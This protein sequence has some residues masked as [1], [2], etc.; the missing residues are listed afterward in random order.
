MSDDT[1][2]SVKIRTPADL[3]GVLPVQVGFAPT[4]SLVLMLLQGERKLDYATL[5]VD[6]PDRR[7][8]A[9]VC[10]ELAR[11]LA[12]LAVDAALVVVY[13]EEPAPARGLV[14]APFVRTLR[15]ALGRVGIEVADM[16]LVR[17][18]RWWCYGCTDSGGCPPEGTPLPTQPTSPALAL[19]AEQVTRGVVQ[20]PSREALAA[21][22]EG[23][24]VPA[25]LQAI[26][27]RVG[28]QVDRL[29]LD[30]ESRTLEGRLRD[31]VDE[32]DAHWE[33]GDPTVSDEQ[34]I[35]LALGLRQIRARDRVLTMVTRPR[36]IDRLVSV[37]CEIVR[38]V[39]DPLAAPPCAVL[40]WYAYAAGN[41]AL[42]AL[43][44]E[45]ALRAEPEYSLA[46]LVLQSLADFVPPTVIQDISVAV[47]Q[48]LDSGGDL[49][50]M[51]SLVEDECLYH[52][53]YELCDELD[54]DLD[55]Y[56]RYGGYEAS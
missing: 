49:D 8:E 9:R 21:T 45:R 4:E 5:R 19:A 29:M 39:P 50:L 10:E 20:Q 33:Q 7:S 48:D 32:L 11:R 42:A 37:F 3:L 17:D 55:D 31:L 18:G 15:R 34:A 53:E 13:T 47:E 43:A 46:Q 24:A 41:G 52:E 56:R 25:D 2:P 1:R 35:T 6:L 23:S 27:D 16:L 30:V 22:V 14:R 12:R 44:A 51:L 28:P 36:S 40:A 38:R 54:P 26:I